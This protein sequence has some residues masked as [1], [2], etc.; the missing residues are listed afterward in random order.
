MAR[1]RPGSHMARDYISTITWSH[2]TS[3]L[4]PG[5]NPNGQ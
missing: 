1:L 5:N 2:N 4:L 3:T